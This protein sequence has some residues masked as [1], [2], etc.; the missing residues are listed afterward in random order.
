MP[1]LPCP[2]CRAASF[3]KR[4]GADL[5]HWCIHCGYRRF[6]E[7]HLPDGM[8]VEHH[9]KRTVNPLP[10]AGTKLR[11]CLGILV[12]YEQM[13]TVDVA[14]RL[15]QDSSTTASQLTV[16][17]AKGLVLRLS[18]KKGIVGGS[19]WEATPQAKK[20]YRKE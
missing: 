19:T 15:E 5:V 2:K 20:M 13:T 14:K 7:Q 10:R 9:S 12:A 6:I 8:V 11:K 18:E 16:L 3:L 1:K 17:Q 4:E